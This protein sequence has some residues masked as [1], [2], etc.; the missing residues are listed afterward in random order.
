MFQETPR[1]PIQSR[2][3]A[4]TNTNVVEAHLGG[5]NEHRGEGQRVNIGVATIGGPTGETTNS[6]AEPHADAVEKNP[7]TDRDIDEN[8][9][10]A[11]QTSNRE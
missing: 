7:A 11:R 5:E 4:K 6:N 8:N 9:N 3:E 1:R 2:H 10:E